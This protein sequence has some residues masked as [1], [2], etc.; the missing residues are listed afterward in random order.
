M[1]YYPENRF[2]CEITVKGHGDFPID[3]LRYE[4][5]VPFSEE[6]SHHIDR[7]FY[8][9]KPHTVRLLCFFKAEREPARSRWRSFGW[10]V[11]GP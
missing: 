7:T 3:M 1:N 10:E 8:E 9:D 11:L 6:D 5:A 4:S 2:A